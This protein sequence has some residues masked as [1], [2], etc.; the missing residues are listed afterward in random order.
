VFQLSFSNREPK[1]V[2]GCLFPDKIVLSE[3][4]RTRKEEK[5]LF[6]QNTLPIWRIK[7]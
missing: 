1:S 5:R 4:Q 2:F 3:D 6:K 7:P